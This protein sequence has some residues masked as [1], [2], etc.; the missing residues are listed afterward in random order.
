MKYDILL[1][2]KRYLQDNLNPNTAKT[3]YSA[4]KKVFNNC[5]ISSMGDIPESYILDRLKH[6]RTK[7]EV[8]AAKNG[9]KHLAKYD[10]SL[11]L[12]DDAAFKT[13][14]KRNH[15]KSKGKI[16]NFDTMM[17]KTNAC[18][19]QR[20]K[21]AYRLAAVSGLR[22]S[23]LAALDPGDIIFQSDGRLKIHV[24]HGK[25]GKEGW[26]TCLKDDYLYEHLKHH[27][28]TLQP[29]E[30]LFYDESYMRKYA[31]EHGMEM[32]DFRRAFAVL[33][34]R[35]LL[36]DGCNA[37][38]ADKIVQEQLR[39]SRFSNTKRYLY[40]RKIIAKKKKPKEKTQIEDVEPITDINLEDYSIQEFY[41][42]AS[43]LDSRDLTNQE[44]KS[45]YN[46]MGSEYRDMNKVLNNKDFNVPDYILQ[47]IDTITECL[48][49][50]EIPREEIVYRGMDNLG[51]LFGDDG[52]KLSSEELNQKYSGTLFISDGFSSTSM[53]KQ[54]ATAYA[55]FEE[56][57]LMRIKIPEKMRG[58]YLGAVNRYRE[59]ELLLQRSS[60]FK[61]DA[62]EKKDDITYVDVSLIYQVKK[63]GK[64]YGKKH[65]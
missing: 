43:E 40:G 46:Y 10:S 38:D 25:G 51:V 2:F 16:V 37:K 28:E 39:H 42:L 27:I 55:G 24:R 3:Y 5:N 9:L 8:S 64:M 26:V 47:D 45:L 6:F 48:E 62:I 33:Q 61:L 60:I 65:K 50:K 14:Q 56:G 15:V 22:V 44:K 53:D 34:K 49:R 20:M 59:M 41:D 31:W 57:V 11:K 13:I 19:D 52:K 58:M 7:N 30:R 1:G 32:H 17:K 23:E 12:P 18:R 35:E 21:Y 4:V 63:K 29:N 36:Q 54:I